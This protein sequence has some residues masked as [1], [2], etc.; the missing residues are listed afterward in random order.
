MKISVVRGWF[1]T[2]CMKQCLVIESSANILKTTDNGR[3]TIPDQYT[4]FCYMTLQ[5][6]YGV[7]SMQQERLDTSFSLNITDSRKSTKIHT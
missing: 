3:Q 7:L 6:E 4:K 2:G 1:V 5:L